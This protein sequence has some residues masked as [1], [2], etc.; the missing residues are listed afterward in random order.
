MPS[1]KNDINKGKM[2]TKD[3]GDPKRT[4]K[5]FIWVAKT[6]SRVT[7]K[8]QEKTSETDEEERNDEERT[9]ET[10]ESAGTNETDNSRRWKKGDP[11]QDQRLQMTM[12]QMW[13][14]RDRRMLKSEEENIE[15][16]KWCFRRSNWN[17]VD[18]AGNIESGKRSQVRQT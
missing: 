12:R 4:Q 9:L 7:K 16:L 10:S 3:K 17:F 13:V 15:E 5:Y 8:S 11:A 18:Q 1:L 2:T 6:S 14:W